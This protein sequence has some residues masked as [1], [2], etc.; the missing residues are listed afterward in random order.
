MKVDAV[1]LDM[2]GLMLNTEPVYK[3]A[4]QHAAAELGYVLDDLFY[5]KLTGRPTADCE[6]ELLQQFGSDFP[7][8]NFRSRWP[9]LWRVGATKAG[10]QRKPGLLEFL[11]FTEARCL[12]VAVATSS[13]AEYTGISL[14]QAGLEGRFDV[15]VT[16]DQVVRGK[17]APDIYIEAARRLGVEPSKCLALEDSEAG[18]LAASRAGMVSLLIPDLNQPSDL[19]VQAAF[20]VLQSLDEARH[21]MATLIAS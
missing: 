20:R 12:P 8:G 17:P 3:A 16:G 15:V 21:M 9:K 7:L 18:I 11:A 2:D 5:S 6:L 4:W 13:D 1:V 19:A 14:R 10:I